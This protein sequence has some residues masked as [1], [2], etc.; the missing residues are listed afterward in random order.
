MYKFIHVGRYDLLY[1]APLE[2]YTIPAGLN[3]KTNRYG[4]KTSPSKKG[5]LKTSSSSSSSPQDANLSP[6]FKQTKYDEKLIFRT[7]TPRVRSQRYVNMQ[8]ESME[9]E[10]MEWDKWKGI[11][12][13]NDNNGNNNIDNSEDESGGDDSKNEDDHGGIKP[14]TPN[15]PRKKTSVPSKS[16][17]N[18]NNVR[19]RVMESKVKLEDIEGGEGQD[20]DDDVVV[21]KRIWYKPNTVDGWMCVCNCVFLVEDEKDVSRHADEKQILFSKD[22]TFIISNN[23]ADEEYDLIPVSNFKDVHPSW[24][25]CF[26]KVTH[27]YIC[28]YIHTYIHAWKSS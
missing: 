6:Y 9:L 13:N 21:P 5:T 25:G 8:Q 2:R 27:T 12:H 4:G 10:K 16:K 1:L 17:K 19:E 14:S 20:G 26:L 24:K 15:R 18:G 3:I 11:N 22:G 7:Y 23:V 28:T